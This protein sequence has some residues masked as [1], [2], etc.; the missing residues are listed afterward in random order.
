VHHGLGS[1]EEPGQLSDQ[2]RGVSRP[3]EAQDIF[4][5]LY[6]T[7]RPRAKCPLKSREPLPLIN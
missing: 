2:A 4:V 1:A 7:L 6:Q 5:F 3:C